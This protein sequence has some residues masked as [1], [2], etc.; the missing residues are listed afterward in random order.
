MWLLDRQ[1]IAGRKRS[2][3]LHPRVTSIRSRRLFNACAIKTKCSQNLLARSS[4]VGSFS[5]RRSAV[6]ACFSHK[7]PSSLYRRPGRADIRGATCSRS[8][9]PMLSIRK[10]AL[11]YILASDIFAIDPPGKVQQQLLEDSLDEGVVSH[12]R[13]PQ[14]SIEYRSRGKH[15]DW[16]VH[17][18]E[19]PLVG[20][21]L[22]VRM[23]IPFAQQKDE[24][25][26]CKLRIDVSE[27][28]AVKSHVPR[29][30]P[31]EL[32]LIWH[33]KHVAGEEMK[34]VVVA[35][36]QPLWRAALVQRDPIQPVG[37]DVVV[38]LL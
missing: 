28:D 27:S 30:E 22:T 33:G 3:P 31:R 16:R 14:L 17:A 37:Y 23:H 35:P 11:E 4:Y 24:L 18:A 32:P 25:L 6:E 5:A 15:Q 10:S 12:A 38:I 20:R 34:P 13:I 26:L 9:M 21:H 7:R 19:I 1:S 36:L 2:H 8:K 29:R